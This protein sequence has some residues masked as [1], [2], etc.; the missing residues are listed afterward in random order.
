MAEESNLENTH[1]W[2]AEL[3]VNG[4]AG[5]LKRGMKGGRIHHPKICPFDIRI[6]WSRFGK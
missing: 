3:E 2:G 6:T 1:T 4:K 5:R